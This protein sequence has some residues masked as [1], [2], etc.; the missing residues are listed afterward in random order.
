MKTKNLIPLILAI[1][2]A[3]QLS[4]AMAADAAILQVSTENIYLKAGQENTIKINLMNTGDYSL[5]DAEAFLTSAQPGVSILSGAH[6][7]FNTIEKGKTKNYLPVIY[8]DQ[9][10]AL[11]AYSLSLTVVYRRFGADQDSQV[12]IPIGL[13]VNEGYVPKV[14]YTSAQGSVKAKSGTEN[15]LTYTF[16][17]NW[18]KP[19]YDL[20]FTLN[21]P[22]SYISVVDGLSTS[23]DSLAVGE[24][25]S[26]QPTLSVLEGTPLAAYTV[27]ATV[28]YK[29]S[30]GNRYH[31][32]FSL[33]V[34]VD[35]ASAAKNTVVTLKRMEVMQER[36]R[37]GDVFE[38]Q[39]EVQC[40]GADAYELLSK[41]SFGAMASISPLTP[42]TSSLGDLE[43]GE[44][45]TVTYRLLVSGDVSAGQYPVTATITY[46][47]SRGVPGSLTETLTVMIEGLIEFEFIDIPTETARRGE[48]KELEADLLLIGTES[49]QFV[50]VGLVEDDVF[51]R[52]TGST[53]YIGA[54]D[55]DSPIP[56]DINYKV[57]Q[58]AEEGEHELSLLIQYRDHLNREHEETMGFSMTVGGNTP[59]PGQETSASGIWV[60]VRRL[61]GLGP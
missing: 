32:S 24:S 26:L 25:V 30:T 37:P 51:Q 46:T 1:M 42:T 59:T 29:D 53:E 3:S 5:Y 27:T 55:P 9:S 48:T 61:L 6:M 41:I 54:V 18:N 33:P 7:V 15:Q 47:N 49:V 13:I 43:A 14:K 11:G 4:P 28:S 36:V 12:T 57:A 38:V 16:S 40:S 35:S 22:T 60:W 23:V 45:A 56:F 8:I 44:T 2:V 17:N 20:D 31:Q 19:L 58:D 50:S 21:S 39:L 52:V 34:N 10:V